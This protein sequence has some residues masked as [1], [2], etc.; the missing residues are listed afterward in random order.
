MK[1]TG[2]AYIWIVLAFV[3][4][5]AWNLFVAWEKSFLTDQNIQRA[6]WFIRFILNGLF[7]YF[8]CRTYFS[9]FHWWNRPS[10]GVIPCYHAS[11]GKGKATKLGVFNF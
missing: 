9:S 6:D 2:A 1:Q 10:H 7:V 4:V 3:I 11:N 5:K 8:P